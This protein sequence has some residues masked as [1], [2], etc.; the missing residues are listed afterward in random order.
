M[1]II[2]I[3]HFDFWNVTNILHNWKQIISVSI[4]CL[5]VSKSQNLRD[6]AVFL[7][8][9]PAFR[10][11]KLWQIQYHNVPLWHHLTQETGFQGTCCLVYRNWACCGK[12]LNSGWESYDNVSIVWYEY[13]LWMRWSVESEQVKLCGMVFSHCTGPGPL[14]KEPAQ[15]GTRGPGT[16]PCLRPVWTFLHYILE[17]IDSSPS[18]LKSEYTASHIPKSFALCIIGLWSI[19]FIWF[20]K[21]HD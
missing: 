18:L 14:G 17:P 5:I 6:C 10:H 12:V 2:V 7:V 16:Y 11:T 21:H 13:D 4:G 3:F 1:I 15:W 9:E 8:K 20:G 19:I